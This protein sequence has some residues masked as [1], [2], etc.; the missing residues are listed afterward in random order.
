MDEYEKTSFWSHGKKN[1]IGLVICVA[2][3]FLGF[4]IHGNLALYLN[5]SGFVIVIGGTF[6]ATVLS[7]RMERLEILVKVLKASYSKAVRTPDSI[8][9][10]LVDL[11][12]KRR[13]KGILA[14]QDDEE[15]TTIVFLRYAYIFSYI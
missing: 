12:V 14:L 1:I 15:E 11:S 10:I 3:F 13:I 2:L 5:I 9:E 7:Y 8:V 6:G 4:V